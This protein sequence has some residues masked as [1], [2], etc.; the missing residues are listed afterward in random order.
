M[1]QNIEFS[2]RSNG[3]PSLVESKPKLPGLKP[4][5]PPTI[6]RPPK[7]VSRNLRRG[8]RRI[9]SSGKTNNKH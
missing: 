2:C 8:M 3:E 6:K 1:V 7:D 5:R 9:P 4:E